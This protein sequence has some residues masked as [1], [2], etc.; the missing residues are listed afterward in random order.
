MEAT[1]Q[2]YGCI[3][4]NSTYT[5]T[6]NCLSQEYDKQVKSELS[7]KLTTSKSFIAMEKEKAEDGGLGLGVGC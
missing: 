1:I 7:P 6:H 5:V 3:P 2:T 4:S